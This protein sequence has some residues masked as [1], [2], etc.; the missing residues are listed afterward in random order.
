[1]RVLLVSNA[2]TGGAGKACHRLY[3]ALRARGTD[4]RLLYL[5]GRGSGDGGVVPFYRNVRDLFLRQLLHYPR[6]SLRSRLLGDARRR[7]RLPWSIHRMERHPLVE[8]AD[9]VNLHWVAD[10]VDYPRFFRQV[11]RKPAVWTLHDMLPFSGGYHYEAD[12]ED[13][14]FG[15]ERRIEA[16]KARAVAGANL[17]I[18]APSSWLLG[19]SREHRPF[20]E[21]RHQHIFNG[22]PLELYK[23]MS[24]A[25]AREILNLPLD[26]KILL[27]SA[28]SVTSRR[29]GGQ[30]LMEALRLLAREDVTLV[31]VGRGRLEMDS[32]LDHRHLG[33]L[34]DEVSMAICYS[35][36]DLVVVPSIED[37]SPNSIVESLACGRPVVAFRVGGIGELVSN[38]GLGITV[39]EIGAGALAGAIDRALDTDFDPGFIRADAEARFGLDL[40]ARNYSEMYRETL[41][42]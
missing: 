24:R 4:V 10:F 15:V 26:K 39:D 20:R 11:G 2:V 38:P 12:L 25:R 8:W 21:R 22:L 3:L 35:C 41:A 14:D 6:M 5:E 7:Y 29:K 19:V 9:V 30:Y 1:M 40:L 33:A 28:D 42:R 18:V 13:R 37:N 34:G 31:S 32:S 27:F 23:P 36:A 17:A 16:V